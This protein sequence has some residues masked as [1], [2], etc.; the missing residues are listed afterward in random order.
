MSDKVKVAVR[1]RPFN[2]RG[3]EDSNIRSWFCVSVWV[4][5]CKQASGSILLTFVCCLE[6]DLG[7]RVVVEMDETQTWLTHPTAKDRQ[8]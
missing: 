5:F 8:V 1:V 2:S 3:M 6:I 7:T 4:C